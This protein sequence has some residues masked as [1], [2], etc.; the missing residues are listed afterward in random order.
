MRTNIVIDDDL[1][2][3]VL[4]ISEFTTKKEA[5]NEGLK[6]L[7]QLKK[8]EKVKNLRG[9]LQWEGASNIR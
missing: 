1:M 3:E 5:V 7:I 9:K 2:N 6:V 4:E 8:Q